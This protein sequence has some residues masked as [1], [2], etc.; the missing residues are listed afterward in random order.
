MSADENHTAIFLTLFMKGL[1]MKLNKVYTTLFVSLAVMAGSAHADAI[2]DVAKAAT[3]IFG[4]SKVNTD[5]TI[6]S[7]SNGSH[8]NADAEAKGGGSKAMAGGVVAT[9]GGGNGALVNTKV[10]LGI[11]DKSS[12][13]AKARAA[14]GAE[15]YAGGVISAGKDK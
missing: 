9:G 8:V 4:S 14:D 3:S 6:G 13:N 15:A 5:V 11:F 1:I 12:V 7:F 2:G 10:T